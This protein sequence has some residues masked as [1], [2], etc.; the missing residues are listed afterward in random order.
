M[1]N[2]RDHLEDFGRFDVIVAGSG[3]GGAVSAANLARA[4]LRVCILERG[5]WWGRSRG[6][7][8]FPE[9]TLGLLRA[10]N[11][12]HLANRRLPLRLRASA[13]GLLEVHDF[14]GVRVVGGIGVGGSSLVYAGLS[15]RPPADFFD[16]FP[17]EITWA[18]MEPYYRR[19]EEVLAPEPHPEISERTRRL[20][21][22]ATDRRGTRCVRLAQAITWGNGGDDGERFEN[23]WGVRQ[24]TCNLC[25]NCTPGCNRG[26]KNSLDLNLVAAA[27]GDGAKLLDLCAVDRVRPAGSGYE[28]DVRDLRRR[29]HVTLRAPHVVLAAGTLNTHKILF[30]SR[31]VSDGLRNLSPLLGRRFSLGGDATRGYPER[32]FDFAYGRGHMVEAALEVFDAHEARD[33]FVFPTDPWFAARPRRA[34]ARQRR[35][36]TLGLV[37]FGRDAA[38]GV[39][40]WTGR[41]LRLEMPPQEVLGRIYSTMYAVARGYGQSEGPAIGQADEL[42]QPRR[43]RLSAHP[44]GGCRMGSGVEDGVVDSRGAVF[45]YPGLWVGDASVF[46][47]PP[48]CAPSLSVAALAWRTS[49]RILEEAGRA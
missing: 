37:G 4:G 6:H 27:I 16:A 34:A 13:R 33:H 38:N 20:E 30:R 17:P 39:L 49:E 3:F 12:L 44:M 5:T 21:K 1:G 19:I 14:A 18:E 29:R 40:R 24:A 43:P 41:Q 10:L 35:D 25:N 22:L 15:Q 31:E 2:F 7:R 26:A 45:G 47:A 36:R 9:S 32:D 48:V 28:V 46:C 42:P 23:R 8:P 11:T